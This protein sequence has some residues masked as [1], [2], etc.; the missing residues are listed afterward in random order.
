MKNYFSKAAFLWGEAASPLLYVYLLGMLAVIAGY[1][2]FDND[3]PT[4]S[5]K[6]IDALRK[7]LR[8]ALAEYRKEHGKKLAE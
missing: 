3:A 8:G 5:N 7:G 4:L 6:A 2:I 1:F